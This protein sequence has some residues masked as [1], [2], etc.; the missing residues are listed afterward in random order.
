MNMPGFTAEASLYNSKEGGQFLATLIATA[1][2]PEIIPQQGDYPVCYCEQT[3]W[4]KICHCPHPDEDAIYN[5]KIF[6]KW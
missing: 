5:V 2:G 3:E 1:S 4:G 6:T